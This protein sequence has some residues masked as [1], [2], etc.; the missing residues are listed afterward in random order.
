MLPFLSRAWIDALARAAGDVAPPDVS[1]EI[2]VEVVVETGDAAGV[3]DGRVVWHLVAAPDGLRVGAGP[4]PG[5]LVRLTADIATAA[6]LAQGSAN[7]Q[8]ALG[9]GRLRIG[10]DLADLAR[11]R[12]AL[13]AL[14]D[15]FGS[16][17]A[18]TDFDRVEP[19]ST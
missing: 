5:A 17:R 11:A 6:A 13:D 7:A 14:G 9:Q 19:A 8:R 4:F 15:V 16:V 1:D 2:A 12:G 10:G 18:V 3:G